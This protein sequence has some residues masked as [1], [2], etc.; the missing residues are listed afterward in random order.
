[1]KRITV[2]LLAFFAVVLLAACGK[3]TYTVTFDTQGG[4]AVEALKVK[5]GDLAVR[6]ENNPT[7]AAD[8]EGAWAFTG[9]FTAK[10]GKTTFDFS[11]PV[12]ENVTVYA[13]WTRGAVVSFNTK[14]SAT[15][16]SAVVV[17]GAEVQKPADP[18]R[19]GFKFCGWFKT[20]RGLTWLEPEAVKFPIVANESLDLYAYWEPVNSKTANWS[21]DESFISSITSTASLILNPLTYQWSH[22]SDYI[23]MMSSNL[24]GTEVDWDLA[25]KDGVADFPGDFSK[26]VAK[27][28]SIEALDYKYILIG[29]LRYPVDSQGEEHLD[30]DGNYDRTLATQVTDS[31]WTYHL[32]PA[33]K[34][35]DGTPVTAY[36]YEYTLQQFLSRLQ[37][38]YRAD[39]YYKT[40]KNKN[41]YPL[42]N[43]YEYLTQKVKK[44][45]AEGNPVKGED[46]YDVYVDSPEEITWDQ[47][48]FKVIDEYTFEIETWEVI[49]QA[50]AVGFGGIDLVHPEKYAASLSADGTKSTYGTPDNPYVSYGSY[51]LKSW[52]ENQKLV[53]NKNYDYVLK[54]TVNFKSQIIEV[55]DNEDQKMQLFDRGDL[56]VAGLTKD[57]FKYYVERPDVYYSWSSYPQSLFINL[58]KSK[59][60][61]GGHVHPTIMY[62]VEFRKA[63]FFGFDR[64]TYASEIYAPNTPS[65]FAYPLNVKSYLQDPLRYMETPEHAAVLQKHNIDPENYGYVPERAQSLFNAAYQRW[66]AAGNAGK[67]SLIMIGLNDPFNRDLNNWVIQNYQELFGADKFEI[68]LKEYD[69][70]GL[71]A[72]T[73][74]WNFDLSLN[75]IGF[76]AAYGA[77]WQMP[78]IAFAG[79]IWG[80]H[81]LGMTQPLVYNSET[82]QDEIGAYWK[83]EIEVNLTPTYEYLLELDVEDRESK[84]GLKLAFEQLSAS[85]GK[86]A[87]IWRGTVEELATLVGQTSGDPYDAMAKEPFPGATE[88]TYKIL[89][90]FEDVFLQYVPIIPAVTRSGAT[91]YAA[92][93]VIEWPEYS[94]TF[95]WG[96]AR[97]R[98]L[99]TDPDFQ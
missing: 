57:H 48:G 67:V 44:L 21:K 95:G 24:Y 7:R 80:G 87:G 43:S 79:G 42:V 35:E 92:N 68:V 90:A 73:R 17:P 6:P 91:I 40:D 49:T 23:E 65:L 89:A 46:G 78:F 4:S 70:T 47:V 93:V 81:N 9:W 82:G 45:D 18:V 14:T 10:D 16:E 37:N 26:I 30:A 33:V 25:I 64:A 97:Y 75:S 13:G 69:Q 19:D 12:K 8:A 53:F 2:L 88:E 96:A 83:A 77:Q 98:Y 86:P 39:G 74:A 3:K 29:A 71:R 94:G 34:F 32:N 66:L 52:D 54:G 58:A 1:M 56:S 61:T 76:G 51:V 27:E 22:E 31:K 5:D 99:T 11:K 59:K 85:E 72:E 41:G 15:I 62:D 55:V 50:S 60:E 38:N 84:P 63:L 28:Y 20:K 36:T